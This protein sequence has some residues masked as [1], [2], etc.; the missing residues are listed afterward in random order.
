MARSPAKLEINSGSVV[1]CAQLAALCCGSFPLAQNGLSS[2]NMAA[3]LVIKSKLQ[4]SLCAF[5]RHILASAKALKQKVCHE[6][7]HSQ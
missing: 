4:V 1:T 2:S 7:F 5:L 3:C 6:L